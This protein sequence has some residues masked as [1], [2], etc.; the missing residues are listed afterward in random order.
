MV[1]VKAATVWFAGCSG[2]HMSFLDLDE[3]LFEFA[4]FVDVVYSPI[5]DVKVYPEDVDV[6]LVEGAVSN[7]EQVEMAKRIRQRTKIV[8]AFGDCAV[9]SNVP[10]MRNPL[11]KPEVVLKRAYDSPEFLNHQIPSEPG[12][13]PVLTDKVRPLHEVIDVD[14][15]LPGCPPPAKRIQTA[16]GQL[17]AGGPVKLE[18]RELIKFG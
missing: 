13:L 5:A 4:K 8:I 15:Y 10:A 18:G 17:L 12:I 11:G 3:W 9:T 16:L 2:C 14:L 1:K 7:D 6:C